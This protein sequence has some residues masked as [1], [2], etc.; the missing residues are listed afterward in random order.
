MK[1]RLTIG[2]ERARLAPALTGEQLAELLA[3]AEM[4]I[5]AGGS[6]SFGMRHREGI[7][8]ELIGMGLAEAVRPETTQRTPGTRKILLTKLGFCTLFTRCETEM[9]AILPQQQDEDAE[10]EAA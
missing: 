5:C 6:L 1:R 10:G 8:A 7:C 3:L 9:A 4:T 2:A